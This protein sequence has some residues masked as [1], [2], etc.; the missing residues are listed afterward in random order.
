MIIYK[1]I[2]YN[3]NNNNWHLRGRLPGAVVLDG[4]ALLPQR[5]PDAQLVARPLLPVGTGGE[6]ERARP[7]VD[8]EHVGELGEAVVGEAEVDADVLALPDGGLELLPEV[9]DLDG[10]AQVLGDLEAPRRRGVGEQPRDLGRGVAADG[11]LLA[12][13]QRRRRSQRFL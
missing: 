3:N 8:A 7:V 2:I 4:V 10:D 11:D 6:E 13:G 1:T 5:G 9:E 12:A